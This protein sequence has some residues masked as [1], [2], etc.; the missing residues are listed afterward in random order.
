MLHANKDDVEALQLLKFD[1]LPWYLLAIFDQAEASIHAA[2][3]P[4]ARLCGTCQEPT[5][6]S[7]TCWSRPIRAVF[8]TCKAQP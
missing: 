6:V 1:I 5:V 8:R 3:Y 2:H 4:E 7:V